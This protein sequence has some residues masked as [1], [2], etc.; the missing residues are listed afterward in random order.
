VVIVTV[1]ALFE[2]AVTV[3]VIPVGPADHDV[4]P[5]DEV[6]HAIVPTVPAVTL[7]VVAAKVTL[8]VAPAVIVPLWAPSVTLAVPVEGS[9]VGEVDC[10]HEHR[11]TMAAMSTTAMR[12]T[13]FTSTP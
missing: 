3:A 4:V 12:G 2:T 6:Y 10:L 8:P 7:V 5:A 13:F 9:V 11:V 1:V